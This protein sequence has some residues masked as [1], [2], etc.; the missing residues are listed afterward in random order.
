MKK[1]K[2][3]SD[4]P[5]RWTRWGAPPAIQSGG[6]I[7]QSQP[8]KSVHELLAGFPNA[9]RHI[10]QRTFEAAAVTRTI[11]SSGRI[12]RGFFPYGQATADLGGFRDVFAPGCFSDS[13][14]GDDIVCV[15]HGSPE[16]L[17]GRTASGTLSIWDDGAGVH[18]SADAP[19]TSFANDVIEL[20]KRGDISQSSCQFFILEYRFEHNATGERLRII[21]LGKL[22]AVGPSVFSA[23]SNAT[24][25]T[26]ARIESARRLGFQQGLAAARGNRGQQ[27]FLSAP[28]SDFLGKPIN[29]RFSRLSIA[30]IRKLAEAAEQDGGSK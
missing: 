1:R 24:A 25:D 9:I 7:E 27:K 26:D 16:Y 10:Q 29:D 12:V 30:E 4:K 6:H 18:F 13:V 17:L 19:E 15:A 2:M 8:A 3:D 21:T 20:L 22:L 23:L 28:D 14:S 5:R 11:E